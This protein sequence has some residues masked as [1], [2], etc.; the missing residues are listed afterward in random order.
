MCT[1]LSYVS[2]LFSQFIYLL[3]MHLLHVATC[4]SFTKYSSIVIQ[5]YSSYVE[6][7]DVHIIVTPS[8]SYLSLG[9]VG[10]WLLVTFLF[11]FSLV[12]STFPITCLDVFFLAFILPGFQYSSEICKLS[13]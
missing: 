1:G 5:V 2:I 13:V 9:G 4:Y 6:K 11:S 12:F 8:K 10:F 3:F 7:S